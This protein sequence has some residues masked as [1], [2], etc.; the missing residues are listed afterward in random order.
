M[1]QR[2]RM[3]AGGGNANSNSSSNSGS[4]GAAGGTHGNSIFSGIVAGSGLSIIGTSSANKPP[5]SHEPLQPG[6]I[7]SSTSSIDKATGA[8]ISA[9]SDDLPPGWRLV[10]SRHSGRDYYLHLAS[11]HTQWEKPTEAEPK[12]LG[13]PAKQTNVSNVWSSGVSR[14]GA[15]LSSMLTQANNR[16]QTTLQSG[17]NATGSQKMQGPT[18]RQPS[19]ISEH[20][21]QELVEIF[22]NERLAGRLQPSDPKRYSD[23]DATP[24]SGSESF[25]E[26]ELPDGH[27]WAGEW[28]IDQ[29]YTS[30]DRDGWTYA[31]DFAELVRLLDEDLSHATRHPNDS[32]RRR[33]WVR[34]HQPIASSSASSHDLQEPS[35]WS[36]DNAL[37]KAD[38][39]DEDSNFSR[40]VNDN[41][42]PFF[43][44]AQ[45]QQSGF[46][47]NMK[48]PHRGGKDNT[49]DYQSINL[50]D[51]NWLV[52]SEDVEK[53]PTDQLMRERAANLEEQIKEATTRSI[54]LEKNLRDQHDKK[55]KE[56]AVQQKKLDELITEYK[57]VQ[58]ENEE[59]QQN[60]AARRSRVDALRKEATEK[61]LL[62][63]EEQRA[64]NAEMAAANQALEEKAK[65]LA[66]ARMR[67][68]R[69][70]KSLAAAVEEAKQR[71]DQ[72]QK[73]KAQVESQDTVTK[74]LKAEMD[75]VRQV[76]AKLE[77]VRQHRLALEEESKALFNLVVEK[78]AD[79]KF[80]S[81]KKLEAALKEVDGKLQHLKEE[82]AALTKSLAQKPE[83]E[84]LRKLNQRRSDIRSE[85]GALKER[86]TMLL[87]EKR[88]QEG[89]E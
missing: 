81:K 7:P 27:E 17:N 22:E 16:L 88:K 11:G 53:A 20:E 41:D 77:A 4:S 83:G 71:L 67:Y 3:A 23:R 14:M 75:K 21:G 36:P 74:E 25:P 87:A 80:K 37:D 2:L 86:R 32:V 34:Y 61:D 30:V 82:Q 68:K 45:K 50:S 72:F 19:S 6:A 29:N 84:E 56:I 73:A 12:N 8:A 63:N 55:A 47:V 35:A 89:S 31:T 24:G 51:V 1:I 52:N 64:V 49:K 40:H 42:D 78:K 76:H 5:P 60:V 54:A 44:T 28:E 33:R 39:L 48:F 46:R 85:M 59:L 79:M 13:T 15:G 38:Q 9:A 10:T 70:N 18:M 69:D 57:R 43:R 26:G 62:A 65:A 66:T 58:R